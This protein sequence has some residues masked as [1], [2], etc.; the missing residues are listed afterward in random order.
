METQKSLLANCRLFFLMDC[1][2]K[3]VFVFVLPYCCF[4]GLMFVLML[5]TLPEG[6]KFRVDL[7]IYFYLFSVWTFVSC[8]VDFPVIISF[9]FFTIFVFSLFLIFLLCLVFFILFLYVLYSLYQFIVFLH[10]S[11]II[12]S[13]FCLH[14]Y[15]SISSKI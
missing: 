6:R 11:L 3:F 10:S 8:K 7:F 2:V 14:I 5:C 12:P 9:G 1:H 15:L 13:L 4:V